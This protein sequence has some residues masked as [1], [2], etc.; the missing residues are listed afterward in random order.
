MCQDMFQDDVQS[1][2]EADTVAD[3][4]FL[5]LLVDASSPIVHPCTLQFTRMIQG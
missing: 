4:A 3:Q 1:E 2:Q 5:L